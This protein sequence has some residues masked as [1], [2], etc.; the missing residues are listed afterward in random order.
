[1][2][3]IVRELELKVESKDVNE[4][5]QFHELRK[6][7]FEMESNLGKDAVKIV[8]IT[9]DLEYYV[10]LV[11]KA[12]AVFEMIDSNYESSTTMGKMLLNYITCCRKII[13]EK[14]SPSMLQSSL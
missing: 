14:D 12:A 5:L 3:E 7:F 11:D 6:W 1:M 4:F 13:H 2:V 10:N 9:K 8:E